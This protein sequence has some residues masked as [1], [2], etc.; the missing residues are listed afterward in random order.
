MR[1]TSGG[2][3]ACA[4]LHFSLTLL[5]VAEVDALARINA[6]MPVEKR[7][8]HAM[9]AI[10]ASGPKAETKEKLDAAWAA[11]L[12]RIRADGR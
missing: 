2:Q 1:F 5:L 11:M 8:E 6:Q 3:L 4:S 10:D 9:V 12:E 7:L